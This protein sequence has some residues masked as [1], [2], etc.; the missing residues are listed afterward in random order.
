M[1][2]ARLAKL[3]P[4]C[5]GHDASWSGGKILLGQRLFGKEQSFLA[6]ALH[7]FA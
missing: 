2:G 5:A 6:H 1:I 3:M 7:D 4:N